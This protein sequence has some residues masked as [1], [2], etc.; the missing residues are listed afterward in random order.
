MSADRKRSGGRGSN[1]KRS[2]SLPIAASSSMTRNRSEGGAKADP[3]MDR[4][5]LYRGLALLSADLV[6]HVLSFAAP[7]QRQ[8]IT[9]AEGGH[10]DVLPALLPSDPA[11][12]PPKEQ[13][14]MQP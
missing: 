6:V 9:M 13:I 4:K 3:C 12:W 2:L 7:V 11:T 1:T 10:P 8:C 14:M 5:G